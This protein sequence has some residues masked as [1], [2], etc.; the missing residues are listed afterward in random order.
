M[1]EPHRHH[2]GSLPF[3]AWVAAV[4]LIVIPPVWL[5][6][7]C[8]T[9]REQA[10]R[11]VRWWARR[12][13]TVCGCSLQIKGLHYLEVEP[14]AI[15][16]AN[17]SSYLDSVVLVAVMAGDYRFVANQRELARPLV[18]LVLRKGHHLTVDR[19]SLQSKVTC[20][21]AMLDA[22]ATG[23][24]LVLFPE[25]TRSAHQLETFKNGAF[26]A[27]VKSGR[28]IIPVAISGTSRIMPRRFRLLRRGPITISILPAIYPS[29]ESQAT[30]ALRERTAAAIASALA[31][32]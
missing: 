31:N 23:T 28:P 16:V 21:R 2:G 22:L 9:S 29:R 1:R 7:A 4:L 15:I 32:S 10:M 20:L 25:G 24:S 13:I 3:S 12:L 18:G 5:A 26:R 19:R 27:A 30:V 8:T 17:H 14:C 6:L 11:L